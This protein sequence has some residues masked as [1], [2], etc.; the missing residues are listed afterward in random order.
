MSSAEGIDSE[1]FDQY[2][3]CMN[4]MLLGDPDYFVVDQDCQLSLHPFI[5]GKPAPPLV[6]Q[7]T[8]DDA[9]ATNP[10]KASREY[11]NIFDQDGG[12]DVFVKRSTVNKFSQT[13]YPV[14]E[15]EGNKSYIIA[16][17]P[18]S[19]LDNSMIITGE[20]FEDEEKGLMIKFVYAKNLIE[21]L[22]N[23]EKIHIQKPKQIEMLKDIICDFNK[24]GE[25]YDNIDI[26]CI[27]AGAGGLKLKLPHKVIYVIKFYFYAGKTC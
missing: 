17:D 25:D 5:N 13:Y 26:L 7:S 8:I 19:K 27:D 3:L 14:F 4:K 16:Y 21:I 9:F 6:S 11:M 20:L 10:Y 12:A 2:K 15:N 24:G 18:A 23:G 1:L 22:K